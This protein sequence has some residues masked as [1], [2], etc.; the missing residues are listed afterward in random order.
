VVPIGKDSRLS[1][2]L[3]SI[4][5][6]Y[7]YGE[8]HNTEAEWMA[9]F[10]SKVGAYSNRVLITEY[11]APMTAGDDYS[12]SKPGN[13]QYCYFRGLT[14]QFRQ[15]GRGGCYWTAIKNDEWFSLVQKSGSGANITLKINNQSGMERIWYGWGIGGTGAADRKINSE[16]PAHP[17]D[18]G[19]LAKNSGEFTLF[20]SQGRFVRDSKEFDPTACGLLNGIFIRRSGSK[21]IRLPSSP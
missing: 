19:L 8:V 5:S 6:Y 10:Q 14:E 9:Y 2:C 12:V 21:A 18:V 7:I 13:N 1:G 20:D 11:G 4:H 17:A 16:Q 15:W 3:L